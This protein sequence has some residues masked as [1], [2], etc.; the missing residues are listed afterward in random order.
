MGTCLEGARVEIL[1]YDNSKLADAT[2][3][4]T[5][6]SYSRVWDAGPK[7]VKARQIVNGVAS[8]PSAQLEF[9]IIEMSQPSAPKINAPQQGSIHPVGNVMIKGDC[10]EGAVVDVLSWDDSKLA[11]A[12]VIGT[13]WTLDFTWDAGYKHVKARQT[14]NHWRSDPSPEREFIVG[15]PVKPPAPQI[16]YPEPGSKHP[17]GTV[18]IK[19]ICRDRTTVEVLNWDDSKLGDAQVTGRTW[20][21][22]R[23]WDDGYKHVKARQ[24][25]YGMVSDPS[26][27]IEF[28]VGTPPPPPPPEIRRPQ[29]SSTHLTGQVTIEGKCSAGATV[30]VLASDNTPLG[31]AVVSRT[32][33][34]FDFI[35]LP[36][37]KHV[38]ARQTEFDRV[39]LPSDLRT[40]AVK[41]SK[42]AITPPP[43]PAT[44]KQVLTITNVYSGTVTLE[45]LTEAGAKVAG[46]FS[47][48]GTTRTF[49]PT[50]DWASG[51]NKVK[52]VQAVGGVASDPSE[53]AT[54]A[55]KPPI[56]KISGPTAPTSS[57]PTFSGTGYEGATVNVV[58][59]SHATPVLAI[60]TVKDG[61]WVA[62]LDTARPDLPAGPYE[63]SAKQIVEGVESGWL[64]PSFGIK[65][66]PPKPAITPPPNPAQPSQVLTITN[67]YS[68]VA[69]AKMLDGVGSPIS[70]T[71]T[72]SGTTRTFTPT[73]DWAPGSNTVK[74][75]Q[76][77]GGVD[78]DPSD[79]CTF[80][81]EVGEKPEAPQFGL[82]LAGSKTLT[83]PTIRV[84]G[85]P[86]AQ[87]TVRL[88][89]AETL[90]SDAANADGVLEFAV[91][92]PLV[93]GPNALEVKQKGDGPESE[94][95]EPHRFTVKE[96]PQTPVIDAPTAGSRTSR[97][98]TIRGQGET[99]GQILLRHDED[100]E[101]KPFATANGVK[102]W[103]W[104]AKEPWNPGEYTI[105][106]L[107]A[108]DSD[109]SSWTEP[110]T[111]EVVDARYGISD[112]GPVLGQPVVD[113]EQSV[114]LRVQ[115]VSGVTGEVTEGVKVEWR[116]KGEQ[117]VI[118]TTVTGPDG[119]AR[120][121]Y[122]P[123]T[124]GKHE[125]LADITHD[126]QG[127][128]MTELFEVTA[129]LRDAWA[130]ETTLYLNGEPVDLAKE[131][132]VLL[133]GKPY[134]LELNVN[135]GSLLIGSSVML[136]DLWGATERG[137]KFD[138][139]LGEPQTIEEGKL[140]RW[141]ISFEEGNGGFF[142]LNL[143]S[144]ALL[145]W[146]L[147]GRVEA[148][149]L[150]EAVEVDF[151][152]F[153]MVFGGGPAY[154]CLGAAHTFTVRPKPNSLLL[155]KDVTLELT[156]EAADLGVTVN[157]NTPQKMGEDGLSWT[158]DCV[159]SGQKGSFA[160]QLKVQEWDFRSLELP[161]HLGH[162]KVK[163]T[164]TSGPIQ[165]G[166][167]DWNY[168]IRATSSFTM[169]GAGGVPVDVFV[170]G[171]GL[172]EGV[173][174]SNGWIYGGCQ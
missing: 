90:H 37:L 82:P 137:L 69:T 67:I 171:E 14:V 41:P 61:A 19:G 174:Q 59:Q 93:P 162:N 64:N 157:P 26:R 56:P 81:V 144:P 63:L 159:N 102:N 79:E 15:T 158:L 23:V 29:E 5:T 103:R 74:V 62:T 96:L 16:T 114:L 22:S 80:T 77:V 141:S 160:V 154:P 68:D 28:I 119:W 45:M 152:T 115:V 6:L 118:A 13:V 147:P 172:R 142:G 97:K 92:K 76:T 94:W 173:T 136:L 163:I 140:V 127:I 11:E 36:G 85:L 51:T 83:R 131:D 8:D 101:D 105:R 106:V 49:T 168:G 169:Q 17:V 161:M 2:V 38:K 107:Q 21:Y 151:D 139:A 9:F 75:V 150:A 58:Q 35:W 100:A 133:R 149:D 50:A 31:D 126:N 99:R 167:G 24:T 72:G 60:A 88:E 57:R 87:V 1:N 66:Q 123:D 18:E 73:A 32:D 108:E 132:L 113:K 47:P 65:V 4:G 153:A 122:T 155:G 39:S 165:M 12:K 34:F 86:L 33:W 110:R 111:F 146:H 95:S 116:I 71:F 156:Q 121:R 130:P 91:V 46:T 124:P 42:P 109:S 125:V 54:V 3:T 30:E 25:E 164:E 55:V 120:Y 53:L 84:T 7:H 20:S 117:D 166:W 128:V 104:D 43:N 48:S 52:V 170:S 129:L 138:P 44:A 148:G 134:E 112:A 143:T 135:R 89:G 78:S 10:L 145:G 98:P 27:Q 70:G 40:F